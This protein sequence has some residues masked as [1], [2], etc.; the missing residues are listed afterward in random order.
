MTIKQVIRL[1]CRDVKHIYDMLDPDDEEIEELFTS[2]KSNLD[3]TG[4]DLAEDM[5]FDE[6]R[7]SDAHH[8][9]NSNGAE[10]DRISFH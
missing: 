4:V 8:P 2:I 3:T 5:W 9:T 7:S 1:A 10:T 6:P